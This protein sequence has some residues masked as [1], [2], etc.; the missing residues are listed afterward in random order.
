MEFHG[1]WCE[2][3]AIGGYFKLVQLN[4]LQLVILGA[5]VAESV[6]ARLQIGQPGF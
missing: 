2:C 4:S 6:Y 5:G 3:Y 1:I